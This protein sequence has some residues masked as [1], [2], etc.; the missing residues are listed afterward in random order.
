M[1]GRL[2]ELFRRAF[3][4]LGYDIRSRSLAERERAFLAALPE[5]KRALPSLV[6]SGPFAA[7]L[8]IFSRDRALQLHALLQSWFAQVD[9]SARIMVLWT[10][11][12]EHEESYRQLQEIWGDRVAWLREDNFRQDLL[13]LLAG[14]CESHLLFLTDDA[15]VLRPFALSQALLPDPLRRV[16]ALTHGP[17]LD[18][19]FIARRH[20]R[21]P[22]L[23]AAG[24]GLLEWEWGQGEEETDWAFPL[25][26]DGKVFLLAEMRLFLEHLPFRNPNTLE[27]AMQ[28]LQPLFVS[29]KG[30]CLQ[31]CRVVNVPCNTVQRDYAHPD[32]GLFTL[33]VLRAH[34]EKGERIFWEDFQELP[35]VE[36]ESRP[37][38]FV[39]R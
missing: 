28:V 38:R 25:S 12:K 7:L 9:G 4:R 10:A 5:W 13:G 1:S 22:E 3:S 6:P 23:C 35:P 24:A 16:F 18:Y 14:A 2:V 20:Q 29:R 8:V 33:D 39:A 32:T 30:V 19:C 36:A 17:E 15:L 21:V 11:S 26:V 34:W 27:R 31:A 37:Y